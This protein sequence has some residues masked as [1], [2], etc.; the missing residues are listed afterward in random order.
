M[1][2]TV[3]HPLRQ[4][5][6]IDRCAAHHCSHICLPNNQTYRCSCPT[7]HNL[8]P[9]GH[10]C[11]DK[12]DASLLFTRRTDIRWLC[13]ECSEENNID[14]VLPLRDINSV[15][16]IDYDP[17]SSAIYWSDITNKTI[18]RGHWNGFS[19]Q[20]LISVSLES[21]S[22][23]AVDWTARNLYW[24]DSGRN[25]I[26]V[27]RMDGSMRALLVWQSLDQPRDIVLEPSSAVMFWSQWDKSNSKIERAGMDGSQRVVIHSANLTYPHGLAVDFVEKKLYWSDAGTKR[28]EFSAFGK[29]WKTLF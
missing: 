13:I 12:P 19:Q 22:G 7:G 27:S 4:P 21:P 11:R 24:V 2:I 1:D 9:E 10:T 18:S 6:L 5:D 29:D 28:I 25:V 26:E 20:T 16:S 23:L 14:V 3:L 17:E 8:N 15:V